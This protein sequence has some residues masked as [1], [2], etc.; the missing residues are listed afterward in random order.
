MKSLILEVIQ[1][2]KFIDIGSRGI[3]TIV[4]D[5]TNANVQGFSGSESSL[6]KQLSKLIKDSKKEFYFYVCF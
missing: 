6:E 3:D 1:T 2:E 5:S 4:C